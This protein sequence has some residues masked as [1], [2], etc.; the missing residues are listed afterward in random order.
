MQGDDRHLRSRSAV[1]TR[2]RAIL[3]GGALLGL[4]ALAFLATYAF[5][6]M[7]GVGLFDRYGYPIGG[8][9]VVFYAAARL[10]SEG[11]GAGIYPL[12]QTFFAP[13]LAAVQAEVLGPTGGSMVWP[14]PRLPYYALLQAPLSHLPYV[15]AFSLWT[16]VN[17]GLLVVMVLLLAQRAS[18]WKGRSS[19]ALMVAVMGYVPVLECLADGQSGI[20]S[21]ALMITGCIG[22]TRGYQGIAGVAL[23]LSVYKPQLAMLLFAYLVLIRSW[24]AI[25]AFAVTTGIVGVL[26]IAAVGV[27]GALRYVA[28]SSRLDS[29]FFTEGFRIEGQHAL[30]P[31]F[32]MITHNAELALWA[33]LL[34]SGLV[35]GGL[36][37]AIKRTAD[38][39]THLALVMLATALVTPFLFTYDLAVLVA[40]GILL[41][42]RLDSLPSGWRHRTM[43]I[44]LAIA[45]WSPLPSRLA[46]SSL[47]VQFSTIANA[48]L[49]VYCI[50]IFGFSRGDEDQAQYDG[51][52][53]LTWSV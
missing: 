37:V 43:V 31:F 46:A 15:A 47:G 48:V 32:V 42:S 38:L 24:R 36:G 17:I 4:P 12:G 27:D 39:T 22:L 50:Y 3:Y 25:G 8:D 29:L 7:T 41:V 40:P 14:Y 20:L 11:R 26:S 53:A 13:D 16:I 21:L 51:P 45:Y 34:A 49:L 35:L 44:L 5:G 19:V 9:F 2:G 28:F 52:R 18:L 10:V 6:V 23:G 33:T 1:W 30:Y